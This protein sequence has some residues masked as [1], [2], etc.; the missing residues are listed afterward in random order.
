MIPR[1]Q[2]RR[3]GTSRDIRQNGLRT[4]EGKKKR[5]LSGAASAQIFRANLKMPESA[6][7]LE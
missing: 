2:V 4:K 7:E 6:L 5:I 3:I 1:R